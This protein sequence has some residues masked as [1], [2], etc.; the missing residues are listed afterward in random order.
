MVQAL[1]SKGC[2]VAKVTG[3]LC[4]IIT[5]DV[6]DAG[7]DG[8]VYLGI[9]GREF[10]LDSRADDYERGSYR[11]YVL[12]LQPEYPDL[13]EPK[14]EVNNKA[15]NDPESYLPI[16]TENLGLSPVYIRFE[17]ESSGDNWN[18]TCAAA[19]V[20][21][22][23]YDFAVGYTPP[24]DF[25]NL[26][27]GQAMGKVLYLTKEWRLEPMMRHLGKKRPELLEHFKPRRRTRK[28]KPKR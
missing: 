23:I 6:A 24:V 18:V 11:I 28:A 2:I 22:H 3:I 19:W 21:T 12:G 27:M 20:F 14:V 25:D 4:Q 5:G 15:K 17:P 26:W 16:S 13:P 8:N 9:G 1:V 7:T 10:R